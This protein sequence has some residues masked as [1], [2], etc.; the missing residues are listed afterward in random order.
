[1][2]IYLSIYFIADSE[3]GLDG[4]YLPLQ[5]LKVRL[6]S[7][8]IY[9]IQQLRKVMCHIFLSEKNSSPSHWKM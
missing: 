1:M 4:G 6:P 3:T 2:S 7:S 5:A 9:S 8:K